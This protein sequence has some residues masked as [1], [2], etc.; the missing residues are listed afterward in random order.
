MI[1][2]NRTDMFRNWVTALDLAIQDNNDI[3]ITYLIK[4]ISYL[5]PRRLVVNNYIAD[6]I[7][8]EKT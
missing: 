7:Q 4:H 3:L 6:A 5:R 2:F 8:G 1:N